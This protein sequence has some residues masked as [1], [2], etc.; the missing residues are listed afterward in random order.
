MVLAPFSRLPFA[1]VFITFS[2][3][4]EIVTLQE[5]MGVAAKVATMVQSS[6]GMNQN[7]HAVFVRLLLPL[8]VQH[9]VP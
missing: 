3:D 9:R 5:G 6:W 1:N 4:A 8:V 2:A 7:L